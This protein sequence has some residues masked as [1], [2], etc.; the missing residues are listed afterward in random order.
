MDINLFHAFF[1]RFA[2]LIPLLGLFFELGAIIT[3]KD[4]V[5]KISGA[6]VILGSLLAI[7]AGLSGI[8]EYVYLHS[9][10]ENQPFRLHEI[11]GLIL[12]SAF[13]FILI[14]RSYLL[15]KENVKLATFYIFFYVIVVMV[16]LFSNEVVVHTVRKTGI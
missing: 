8:E 11:L 7:V 13:L 14:V 5:S 12:T 15:R 4:L 3:Q 1:G 16:N 2:V 10:N 9:L 6:I